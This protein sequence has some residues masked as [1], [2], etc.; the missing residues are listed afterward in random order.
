MTKHL[1]WSQIGYPNLVLVLYTTMQ[2]KIVHPNQVVLHDMITRMPNQ[3]PFIPCAASADVVSAP[4][5]KSKLKSRRSIST[6]S[7]K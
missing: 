1:I 3:I 7:C 2:P 6:K 4:K 5:Y